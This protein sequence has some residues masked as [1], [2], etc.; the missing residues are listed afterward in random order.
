MSA[1]VELHHI[2]KNYSQT[3]V[4][5]D[6]TLTV[7]KG[8]VFGFVGKN[9]AG[10]TTT[11]RLILGL[12][13][14]D[15][16]TITVLDQSIDFGHAYALGEIG[17]VPDV[18]TFY[19]YMTAQEYLSLCGK[20]GGMTTKQLAIQIPFLL[21]KVGLDLEK[22]KIKGFSRGMKQRLAIAQGLLGSPKLL[23]CDEPTSALDP[24]GREEILNLLASLRQTTTVIFSTHILEDVERI[25][26]QIAILDQGKI[27]C[28]GAIAQLKEQHRRQE[29][30]L[31]I[32]ETQVELWQHA[33][34]RLSDPKLTVT[35][36]QQQVRIT[37][38]MT[39]TEFFTWF[40]S[41]ITEH[42]L[43]FDEYQLYTSSLEQLFLEVVK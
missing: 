33:L 41:F 39:T 25:C 42:Q 21:E 36:I 43:R 14:C 23:I 11:M 26:D 20:I 4:L 30:K 24:K 35:Q 19:P 12:E 10:K 29:V 2:Q 1:V 3:T 38:R 17:Y 27:V 22:R 8:S 6:L 32:P 34:D 15:Q 5:N 40:L 37:Y 18:P 9:G 16:G 31:Q 28:Q 13:P 7:P